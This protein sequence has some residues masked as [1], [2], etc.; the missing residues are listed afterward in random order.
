[1]EAG[2]QRLPLV[3]CKVVAARARVGRQVGRDAWGAACVSEAATW[4][5]RRGQQAQAPPV[6]RTL[7]LLQAPRCR[8]RPRQGGSRAWQRQQQRRGQRQRCTAPHGGRASRQAASDDCLRCAWIAVSLKTPAAGAAAGS[9]RG[10]S[11]KR[12]DR[13]RRWARRQRRGARLLLKAC[14]PVGCSQPQRSLCGVRGRSGILNAFNPV[15]FDD[16]LTH[17]RG[18]SPAAAAP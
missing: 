8:R 15:A 11:R 5:V 1:M 13:H 17:T 18:C 16:A 7:Q 14:G 9:F 4:R 12:W 3:A 6:S 2:A 10:N